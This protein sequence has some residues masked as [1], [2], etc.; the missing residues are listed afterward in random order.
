MEFQL[1]NSLLFFTAVSLT[2]TS[3]EKDTDSAS[4]GHS[5]N[6]RFNQSMD[7]IQ[8]HSYQE[9]IVQSDDY[10][11]LFMGD[12]HVGSTKNLDTLFNI[13]KTINASAVVMA[14]DLTGGD[15][16]DYPVLEQCLPHKDSLLS[17][18]TLGNHDLWSRNG[19][20]EFYTRF[21][22]SCYLFTVRSPAANDLYVSLDSGSGTLGAEQ[23]AWFEDILKNQRPDYRRCIVFTHNNFFRFRHVETNNP[24]VEELHVLI[25]LFTRHHVDMLITGH[26]HKKDD[27]VFGITTYIVM[28]PLKDGAKNAGYLELRVKDGDIMYDFENFD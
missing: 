17:F 27:V 12:S 23:L 19:W 26:D 2:L 7:W 25:E 8:S 18:L 10:N 3:C 4:S 24:L 13:A 1:K 21:G 20:E 16:K 6:H 22:P 14:G 5:V 28:D 11:I 9:I 15:K